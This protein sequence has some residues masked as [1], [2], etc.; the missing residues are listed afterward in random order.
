MIQ[1]VIM[2]LKAFDHAREHVDSYLLQLLISYRS[3]PH[4][5]YVQSFGNGGK[6]DLISHHSSTQQMRKCGTR[7][8]KTRLLKGPT[9]LGSEDITQP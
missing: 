9:S 7:N 3:I 5:G 4:V 6:T 1:T 2:E 8:T